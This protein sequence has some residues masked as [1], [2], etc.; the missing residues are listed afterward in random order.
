MSKCY[1]CG[2]EIPNTELRRILGYH[3]CDNEK[4][5]EE[6]YK[7]YRQAME[8]FANIGGRTTI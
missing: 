3:F 2:K 7:Q 8:F 6:F 4:C 5:I 1:T